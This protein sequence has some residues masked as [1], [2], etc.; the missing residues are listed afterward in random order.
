MIII[1]IIIIENI[2]PHVIYGNFQLTGLLMF[3]MF[4][5]LLTVNHIIFVDSD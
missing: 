2:A 5:T 4:S 1:I 3:E